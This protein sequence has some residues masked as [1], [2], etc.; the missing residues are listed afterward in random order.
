MRLT[1]N[2]LV[3][4]LPK[5]KR[6]SS[7]RAISVRIPGSSA[8]VANIFGPTASQTQGDVTGGIE[9]TYSTYHDY[10]VRRGYVNYA[11]I[12]STLD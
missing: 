7:G 1:G 3:S 2:F 9:D 11:S 8:Y 10:T 12:H 6:T 4:T 5:A